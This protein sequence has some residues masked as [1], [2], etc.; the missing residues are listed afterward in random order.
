VKID[1]AGKISLVTGGT[2]GIGYAI[3]QTLAAR[4]ARVAVLARDGAKA[5][6]VA[7]ASTATRA[8]R[9]ASVWATARGAAMPAT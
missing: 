7:R 8:P 2:R 5:E 9:A 4:G 6:E 1:L 3:A